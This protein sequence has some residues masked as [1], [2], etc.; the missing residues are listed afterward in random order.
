MV[1]DNNFLVMYRYINKIV[2]SGYLFVGE[3]YVLSLVGC[4]GCVV[5]DTDF[6]GI[7]DKED[8]DKD[9]GTTVDITELAVEACSCR[10]VAYVSWG[11]L[12]EEYAE[13]F[14]ISLQ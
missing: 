12:C 5:V 7:G 9:D 11:V 6:D 14:D 10:K 1:S 2:Y 4:V 13:L 8:E 3:A